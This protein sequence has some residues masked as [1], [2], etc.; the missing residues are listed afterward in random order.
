MKKI[1][2]ILLACLMLVSCFSVV[3]FAETKVYEQPFATGTEDCERFRIPSIITLKDGAG[4][5]AA[6][7]LRTVTVQTLPETL[8]LLLLTAKTV[9]QIGNTK[10]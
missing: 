4:V 2:S 1:I 9:I 5:L 8:I 10:E 7:D 3:S 6:A